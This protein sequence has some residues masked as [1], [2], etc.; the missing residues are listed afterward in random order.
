MPGNDPSGLCGCCL[1][2]CAAFMAAEEAQP[3][4]TFSFRCLMVGF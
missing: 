3:A 2:L 1:L 4:M